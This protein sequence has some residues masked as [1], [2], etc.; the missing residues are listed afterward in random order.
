MKSEISA[1]DLGGDERDRLIGG[2]SRTN[3][4]GCSAWREKDAWNGFPSDHAEEWD[5]AQS[6]ECQARMHVGGRKILQIYRAGGA[7]VL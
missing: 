2:S 4:V 5:E 6:S 1:A 7:G 3:F